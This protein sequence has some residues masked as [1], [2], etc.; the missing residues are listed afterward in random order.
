MRERNAE[1]EAPG[2]ALVDGF[3]TEGFERD[4]G[5]KSVIIKAI[6]PGTDLTVRLFYLGSDGVVVFWADYFKLQAGNADIPSSVA[7]QYVTRLFA[8]M[9]APP[10]QH[11]SA[12]CHIKRLDIGKTQELAIWFLKQVEVASH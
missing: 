5:A 3:R 11:N 7:E 9:G 2:R 10:N 6:V 12:Y 1:A 8:L 4:L